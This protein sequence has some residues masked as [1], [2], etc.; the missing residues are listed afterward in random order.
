MNDWYLVRELIA[1]RVGV[2]E[3]DIDAAANLKTAYELESLD[4]LELI[5]AVG[6]AFDIDLTELPNQDRF[7]AGDDFLKWIKG[8]ELYYQYDRLFN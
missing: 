6:Q 2:S 3:E 7:L 1:E 4:I 5:L 8:D